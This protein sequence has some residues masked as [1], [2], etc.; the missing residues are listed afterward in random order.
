M[1]KLCPCLFLILLSLIFSANLL[2]EGPPK[3]VST[4]RPLLQERIVRLHLVGD[5]TM[6]DKI[7]LAYPERGWG[8]QLPYF[9]TSQLQIINHA[10][11]GRSTVRFANEGR[12]QLL[13][14][15]LQ[16]GD[17]VLIQFGHNDQKAE[18]PTRYAAA[19]T[20]FQQYLSLFV[21]QAKDKGAIPLLATPICR[22][23]FDEQGILRDDLLVYANA[24]KAV[25]RKQQIQLIDLHELSCSTIQQLGPDKSQAYFIM[26][27]AGLYQQFPA[28]KTDNTHLNVVG[29]SWIAQLFVRAL[30]H[31]QHPLALFVAREL[32]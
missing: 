3:G 25:A 7:A 26:V 29:A 18:D 6:A 11:N 22:R 17:F 28:G 9:M 19:N 12:W 2:A 10:A 5:S 14:S 23:T 27:P 4:A 1:S 24:T 13:L 16:A 20:T 31:Q 32:L 21:E 30:K 8:Q 15:E